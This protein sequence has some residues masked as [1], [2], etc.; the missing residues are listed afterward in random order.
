MSVW[1]LTMESFRRVTVSWS[2]YNFM[3]IVKSVL[4]FNSNVI[5]S[6]Y[7]LIQH[8]QE[9]CH[10]HQGIRVSKVK[11][12]K[13]W[14][15][16]AIRSLNQKKGSFCKEVGTQKPVCAWVR[17]KREVRKWEMLTKYLLYIFIC[18]DHVTK[19]PRRGG[20][21]VPCGSLYSKC[22]NSVWHLH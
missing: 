19:S 15:G 2:S 1:W 6:H 9:L 3:L 22:K 11:I 12:G 7:K 14:E 17:V 20:I 4:C 8:G 16:W 10:R 13:D 18:C 21:Y 5:T